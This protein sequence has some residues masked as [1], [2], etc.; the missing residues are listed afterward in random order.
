METVTSFLHMNCMNPKVAAQLTLDDDFNVPDV[1]GDIEKCITKSAGITIDSV[2]ISEGRVNVR[3][4]MDFKILYLAADEGKRLQSMGN[5]I[6]FEETVNGDQFGNDDFVQASGVIDDLNISVINTRKISVKAIVTLTVL[7][8]KAIDCETI[9]EIQ[10]DDT[11]QALKKPESL[12]RLAV[13]KKD[14]YR[15]REDIEIP[16]NKLNISEIL[17]DSITLNNCSTKIYNDK[18]ALAGEFKVFFMYQPEDEEAPVQWLESSIPFEGELEVA[19]ALEGALGDIEVGI[20]SGTLAP[21]ADY[22]GEA[23]MVEMEVVLELTMRIYQEEEIDVLQDLYSLRQELKPEC[24]K[25]NCSKLI[26]KNISQCRISD[27][28]KLDR[29][30]GTVL[31][32]LSAQGTAYVENTE[33]C[34]KGIRA[35]GIVVMKLMY[36]AQDDQMPIGI[37]DE[38]IPFTH[39]IEAEEVSGDSMILIRPSLEKIS[40]A[41]TGNNEIEVKASVVLDTLVMEQEEICVVTKVEAEPLNLEKLQTIPSMAGYLVKEG[42]TIWNIAKKYCTTADSIMKNNDKKSD[43]LKK[44]EM[45]FVIK[46]TP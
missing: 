14:T 28:L 43:R 7:S 38:I 11:V 24:E 36:V 17:W 44:G 13:H 16:A 12:L 18:I 19:G 22:D 9:K 2:K 33:V 3:G 27:K 25:V 39:V 8:E 6:S 4:R 32:L 26:M 5:T 10:G 29:E 46:E 41:M 21:K 15:V 42:D 23:R 1:N 20:A 34:E 35:D 40:A 30:Q 31:Q 37:A 45:I